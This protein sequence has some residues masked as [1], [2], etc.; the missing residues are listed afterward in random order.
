ML[1]GQMKRLSFYFIDAEVIES[2]VQPTN[3]SFEVVFAKDGKATQNLCF[4]DVSHMI[5]RDSVIFDDP[6][7]MQNGRK[8]TKI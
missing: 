7:L 8:P 3:H 4:G 2:G 1:F 5:E 6:K